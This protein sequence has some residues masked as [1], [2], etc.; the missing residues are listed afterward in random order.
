MSKPTSPITAS[1]LSFNLNDQAHDLVRE[2][3]MASRKMSIYGAGH[4]LAIKAV[5]KPFFILN[6]IFRFKSYINLNVQRGDLYLLNIRLKDSPFNAQIL[7]FLQLLDVNAVLFE[8]SMRIDDFSF[9]IETLVTRQMTYNANFSFTSHLKKH[10]VETIEVNSELAYDLFEKRKQYRGDVDGDFSVR[11]MVLDQLGDDLLRLAQVRNANETGLLELG[12]D[13]EPELVGYLLP[14]R[15]ASFDPNKVRRVLTELADQISSENSGP[16]VSSDATG[17]Y[18]ALFKLVDYHPDK[19]GILE[20]LEDRHRGKSA[21]DHI[22][23]M[24]ETG[25]I[26][27][28][29]SA[30]IEQLLERQ[31]STIGSDVDTERFIDAFVRLLKTGQQPK[32]AEVMSRLTDLMS[33]ADPGYRQRALNLLG[34]A[35]SELGNAADSSVLEAAVREAI[36]HLEDKTETYEY[37][38]FLWQ[39]FEACRRVERY[40]LAAGLTQAMARRRAMIDNV[41]VY[42]S[43]AVKKGFENI[44]RHRTVE[45]LIDE[46]INAAGEKIQH[47]VDLLVAV[48]TEEVAVG[49]SHVISHPRRHVRQL[50]LKILAELGK[51]SLKV[52]SRIIYDDIMFKRE[53]DRHELP[54][55]KWYVVRNSIFVLGSLHDSQGVPS[56]RTRIDDKDVRV[57]REVISALEKIGCEEAVDCLT[58]MA[59]D[60][61]LEVRDAA[62]IAIGLIADPSAAPILID[63]A[64]RNPRN[65]IKAVTA[66]G[67]LGGNEAKVFLGHLLTEPDRLAELAGGVVGKDDLRIA[68]VK[69]LGQIGDADS[70][71]QVR[72]YKE[73]LSTAQKILFRNSAVNKA[74]SDVLSRH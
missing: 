22:D 35:T 14:E 55:E 69:A 15:M 62:I 3:A 37:S 60:P 42:D 47:L 67:K 31:F 32:A 28:N 61:I 7:Q 24:S 4:P 64:R 9:F 5:E 63:I 44:S 10:E 43:M 30:R 21:D 17:D 50:T 39:L 58:L 2:L 18:M 51:S 29:A 34:L 38:E 16:K 74:I 73:G 45:Q 40:D 46:L 20:N 65:S 33:A 57:R 54:D 36:S 1:N 23:S 59:E 66:L 72:K 26:K 27:I 48:G 8:R 19:N 6:G 49:L 12:I 13:F 41:T 11:R 71:E 52:F 53:P 56:L 25:A 70:I 68:A